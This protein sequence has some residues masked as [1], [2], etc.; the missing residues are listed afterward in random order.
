MPQLSCGQLGPT[1]LVGGL[2]ILR[3]GRLG[4]GL[5]LPR[6]YRAKYSGIVGIL[7]ADRTT[8]RSGYRRECG[9]A[10]VPLAPLAPRH[11]HAVARARQ[12]GSSPGLA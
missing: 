5:G 2:E 7:E 4:V 3:E 6:L 1:G 12:G 8:K 11:P 9:I 10:S